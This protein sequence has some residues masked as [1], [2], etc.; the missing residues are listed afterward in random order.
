MAVN[1]GVQILTTIMQVGKQVPFVVVRA[2]STLL[3]LHNV[4]LKTNSQV[5]GHAYENR[6]Y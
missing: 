5:C 6:N 2:K 3:L 4:Y 1:M